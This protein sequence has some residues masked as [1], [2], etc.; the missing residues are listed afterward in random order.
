MVA[1]PRQVVEAFVADDVRKGPDGR[2]RFS[3]S[4][5]AVVVAWSEMVL[6]APP[7]A[8]LPTL[9][10]RPEVPFS[11][12]KARSSATARRSATC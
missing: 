11:L 2:F 8:P 12:P 3:F 9:I 7:I 5:S 1:A 10:I 6:P 4:P